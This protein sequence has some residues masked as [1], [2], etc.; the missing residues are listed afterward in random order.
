MAQ[1]PSSFSSPSMYH[2]RMHLSQTHTHAYRDG[3]ANKLIQLALAA[4]R[5]R[6]AAAV[7]AVISV[8]LQCGCNPQSASATAAAAVA[9]QGDA[10]AVQAVQEMGRR[11]R[12]QLRIT[13]LDNLYPMV[14][15]F[16]SWCLT[17]KVK[18]DA[19]GWQQQQQQQHL[20]LNPA[21]I[22]VLIPIC[23]VSRT[24]SFGFMC[25]RET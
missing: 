18:P 24:W 22:V 19:W 21:P 17:I 14:C 12:Q 5:S 2:R 7:R 1:P 25:E 13:V 16:K 15:A 3:A 9:G 6:H 20:T 23:A 8:A 11:L 4:A 10:E